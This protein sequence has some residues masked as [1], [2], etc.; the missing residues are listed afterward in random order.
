MPLHVKEKSGEEERVVQ[1]TK[2]KNDRSESCKR[3][4]IDMGADK[5]KGCRL[6]N[7]EWWNF[8]SG[9]RETNVHCSAVHRIAFCPCRA[10]LMAWF[11]LTCCIYISSWRR[12][13]SLVDGENGLWFLKVECLVRPVQILRRMAVWQA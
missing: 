3:G 10:C 5:G 11:F 8:S 1:K 4:E 2:L 6:L 13:R 12:E 9:D 7:N